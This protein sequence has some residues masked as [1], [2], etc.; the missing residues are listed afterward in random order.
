MIQW[1]ICEINIELVNWK[2]GPL[3]ELSSSYWLTFAESETIILFWILN[4]FPLKSDT[5]HVYRPESSS[6]ALYIFSARLTVSKTP[7]PEDIVMLSANEISL[8]GDYQTIEM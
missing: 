7:L 4:V 5:L 2:S 6:V 8:R 3:E 1:K